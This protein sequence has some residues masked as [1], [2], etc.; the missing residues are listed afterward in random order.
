MGKLS[1]QVKA[2]LIPMTEFVQLPYWQIL[3]TS[4][5]KRVFQESQE[6]ARSM[7]LEGASKLQQGQHL[8]ELQELLL[9]KRLFVQHLRAL[10]NR[11]SLKTAYRYIEGWKVAKRH[12]PVTFLEVVLSAG[13]D[14]GLMTEQYHVGKFTPIVK[15]LGGIP[16]TDDRHKMREFV[17]NMQKTYKKWKGTARWGKYMEKAGGYTPDDRIKTAFRLVR[18][19]LKKV[20]PEQQRAALRKL[21]SFLAAEFDVQNLSVISEQAPADFRRGP[22]KPKT[23]AASA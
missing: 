16:R 3:S 12:L 5:Q 7:F 13:I 2:D 23:E 14:L 4:E 18:M 19:Q 1:T 22:G 9:P 20:A 15:Q 10:H 11:L 8:Y 17:G 21:V 6:L